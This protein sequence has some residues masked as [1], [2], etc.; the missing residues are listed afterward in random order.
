MKKSILFFVVF[1]LIA[2]TGIFYGNSISNQ[3]THLRIWNYENIALLLVGLPFLF[4][5]QKAGLPDV[6]NKDLTFRQQ[7]LTPFGI[8]ILFGLADLVVIEFFLTHTTHTSMP[9]YTQP[10][11]YS[12]FLYSSGAF[13][14]EIFYRLIPITLILFIFSKIKNGA[15]QSQAFVVI[16][17]LSSLREPIEQFPYGSPWWF[18]IYACTTGFGMNFLQAVYYK[19][20]GWASSVYMRLGH[21]LIWH[22]LNGIYIQYVVL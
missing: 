16:A 17:V 15:Y 9:P 1:V 7:F 13:E 12:I 8:G 18:I 2:L 19:R 11:P 21:Y 20:N 10:F 6:C 3:F 14:I 5:Q 4:L 22:I